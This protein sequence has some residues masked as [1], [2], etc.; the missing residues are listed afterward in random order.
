MAFDEALATRVRAELT[1]VRGLEERR[2]FGGVAFLVNGNMS[3]GVHKADLIVRIRPAETAAA[4][5]RPGARIFDITGK[6][7]KGWV[8]VAATAVSKGAALK[9]WVGEGVAFARS[10][11]KK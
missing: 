3:V 7:M 4:L 9:S 8:L 11:P 2:M 6:P 10:L 1:G 5:K